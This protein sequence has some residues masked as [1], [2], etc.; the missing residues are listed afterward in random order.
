VFGEPHGQ[1]AK[2]A[3]SGQR[4]LIT[5]AGVQIAM[6]G[7]TTSIDWQVLTDVVTTKTTI[8]LRFT[9]GSVVLPL[10]DLAPGDA[11]RVGAWA[12]AGRQSRA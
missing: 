10:R 11:E 9:T 3:K 5:P 8:D 1:A 7:V 4:L 2:I 6:P 12:A